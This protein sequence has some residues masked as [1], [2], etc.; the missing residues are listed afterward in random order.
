MTLNGV[1]NLMTRYPCDLT[2]KLHEKLGELSLD[3]SKV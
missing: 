2:Q 1:Q 3:H